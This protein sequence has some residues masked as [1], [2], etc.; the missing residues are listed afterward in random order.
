MKLPLSWSEPS[1]Q[2]RIA[3]HGSLGVYRAL[4]AT[5]RCEYHC[6]PLHTP[7]ATAESFR[8]TCLHL[9][10]QEGR[11]TARAEK[12]AE[13][14]AGKAKSS[15]TAEMKESGKKFAAQMRTDSDYQGEDYEVRVGSV[16]LVL[17]R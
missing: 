13:I 1:E 8:R 12:L 3:A 14:R 11:Q 16:F 7:T 15:K 5:S 2:S 17:F 4:F 10:V 9:A 6:H